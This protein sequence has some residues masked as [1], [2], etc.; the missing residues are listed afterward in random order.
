MVTLRE[1]QESDIDSIAHQLNCKDVARYLSSKIPFPYSTADAKWFVEEG[2][3]M[4]INKAI[5]FQGD[6]VGVVGI[7]LGE[8]EYQCSGEL[9]YWLGKP[10]WGKGIA[11]NAVTQLTN[12]T[13]HDSNICR[14]VAPVYESN[15]PS[16]RVLQKCGYELESIQKK[17]LFKHDRLYDSHVFVKLNS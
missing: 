6:L 5:E 7:E 1:L 11:T 9:G 10:H 8:F 16:M 14:L 4:G 13:F 17:A 12:R 2:A 3:K 15:I